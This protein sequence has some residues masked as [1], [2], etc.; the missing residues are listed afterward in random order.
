MTQVPMAFHGEDQDMTL[1]ATLPRSFPATTGQEVDLYPA[2]SGCTVTEA[3]T[4]LGISEDSVDSSLN[5]DVL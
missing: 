3:A 4:L 2:S 1:T 5:I